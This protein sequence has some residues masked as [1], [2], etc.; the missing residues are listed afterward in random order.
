MK[1]VIIIILIFIFSISLISCS[2]KEESLNCETI[3]SIE[4]IENGYI[5]LFKDDCKYCIKDYYYVNE[6]YALNKEMQIYAMN[7]KNLG[8]SIEVEGVPTLL[9]IEN[10]QLSVEANGYIRVKRYLINLMT[11]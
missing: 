2:K 3:E 1:K 10:N 7:S 6:Y 4:A 9:K 5:F 8:N 11:T